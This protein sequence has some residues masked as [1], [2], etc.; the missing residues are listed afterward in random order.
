MKLI[1]AIKALAS[2][3]LVGF[4]IAFIYGLYMALNCATYAYAFC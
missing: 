1:S 4:A 2:L 3:A